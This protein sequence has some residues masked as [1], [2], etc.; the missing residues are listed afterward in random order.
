M[1]RARVPTGACVRVR[2]WAGAAHTFTMTRKHFTTMLGTILGSV[3]W[4]ASVTS[5]AQ[6]PET[7]Q[8]AMH[9]L[10]T[11]HY[12]TMWFPNMRSAT[13]LSCTSHQC[14][15]RY[16]VVG[17]AMVHVHTLSAAVLT[18]LHSSIGLHA[19]DVT[20]SAWY[21]K[22]V[23]AAHTSANAVRDVVHDMDDATQQVHDMHTTLHELNAYGTCSYN[24]HFVHTLD[25]MSTVANALAA[26]CV[27]QHM[28]LDV[29]RA[30]LVTI[31]N[32]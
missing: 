11:P 19:S 18:T 26:D 23:D 28:L 32:M 31:I 10:L 13:S 20:V 3:A 9:F 2:V 27:P 5:S 25:S 8:T 30:P 17:V 1:W 7:L 16:V 21:N 15:D 12:Q 14:S 29:V 24:R 22:F 6:L 4:R